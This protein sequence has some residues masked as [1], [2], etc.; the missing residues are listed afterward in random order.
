[1]TM[2]KPSSVRIDFGHEGLSVMTKTGWILKGE[3]I[4]ISNNVERLTLKILVEAT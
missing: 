1:M 4:K 2:N 3:T